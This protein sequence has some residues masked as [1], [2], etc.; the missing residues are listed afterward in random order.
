MS[1]STEE[2]RL[3]YN[4]NKLE[5]SEIPS[6]SQIPFRK[7]EGTAN[8]TDANMDVANI[9]THPTAICTTASGTAAKVAT[10]QVLPDFILKNNIEI[11]VYFANKNT[12]SSP[13][14][15]INGTGAFPLECGCWQAKSFVRVKYVDITVNGTRIQ[16]FLV[17]LRSNTSFLRLNEVLADA[18]L[19]IGNYASMSV[20]DTVVENYTAKTGATHN[21]TN[22]IPYAIQTIANCI[23]EG[24][25]SLSQTATGLA[26]G[27]IYKRGASWDIVDSSPSWSDWIEQV[28]TTKLASYVSGALADYQKTSDI[29]SVTFSKVGKTV[30]VACNG[31]VTISQLII[32]E[33]YRPKYS[34]Y[35][36]AVDSS[37]KSCVLRINATT[38]VV[39]IFASSSQNTDFIFDASWITI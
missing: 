28:D 14:L 30:S 24:L 38:G 36:S 26:S 17:D 2:V 31:F 18:N 33:E 29:G 27:K 10:I 15:N 12:A 23:D 16:K 3:A 35:F 1:D 5:L 34:M 39:T 37:Y 11:D 19:A 13:T 21:P 25:I 9:F 4:A 22:N 32:P 6:A 20:G 7:G 8:D